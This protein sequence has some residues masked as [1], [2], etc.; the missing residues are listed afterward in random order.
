[1]QPPLPIPSPTPSNSPLPI[2]N[3]YKAAECSTQTSTALPPKHNTYQTAVYQPSTP[4][5]LPNIYHPQVILA[6]SPKN[7]AATPKATHVSSGVSLAK[8]SPEPA[9]GKKPSPLLRK[10]L[11]PVPMVPPKAVTDST[12]SSDKKVRR[13]AA[14]QGTNG[15]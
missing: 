10:P 11:A 8:A 14:V 5:D 7:T 3:G 1:M 2:S 4:K 13:T 12:A 6:P 9:N 15:P